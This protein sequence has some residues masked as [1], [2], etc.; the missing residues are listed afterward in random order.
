MK[1]PTWAEFMGSKNPKAVLVNTKLNHNKVWG[2]YP[3][4][5]V[6]GEVGFNVLFF[7]GRLGANLQ[8]ILRTYENSHNAHNH[9]Y[10]KYV[11]K[12]KKGYVEFS[13]DVYFDAQ[14]YT[15]KDLID[16]TLGMNDSHFFVGFE[17]INIDTYLDRMF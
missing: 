13:Y 5:N 2:Y 1:F 10:N 16:K 9:T 12:L 11:E 8:T 3:L 6:S 14:T 15:I 17:K 7:Y 4:G